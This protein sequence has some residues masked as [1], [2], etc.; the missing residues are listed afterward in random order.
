M[1][2]ILYE[3]LALHPPFQANNHLSL[4]IKIKEGNIE[5][6]PQRYSDDLHK[7]TRCMLSIDKE[8]RPSVDML[9]EIP[10]V[11][12][13]IKEKKLRDSYMTIKKREEKAK[14]KEQSLAKKEEELEEKL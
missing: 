5:R 2:C 12:L 9:L 6:I 11:Q 13:R 4:A 14:K 3:M 1:G 7:L 8:K 10:S